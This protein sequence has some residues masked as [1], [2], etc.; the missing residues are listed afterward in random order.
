MA[1][2]GSEVSNFFDLG[3]DKA[4]TQYFDAAKK[5][6]LFKQTL[7]FM[8]ARLRKGLATGTQ[9]DELF[10]LILNGSSV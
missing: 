4:Y 1:T 2:T 8:A 7:T 9:Y 3:I 6:R 10:E 5:N